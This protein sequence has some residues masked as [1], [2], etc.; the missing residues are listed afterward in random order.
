MKEPEPITEHCKGPRC[1][2]PVRARGLCDSHY[3]Q[4]RT[5]GR[6]YALQ[7]YHKSLARVRAEQEAA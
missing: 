6:V 5:R 7:P 2:R 4:W 3:R 1:D